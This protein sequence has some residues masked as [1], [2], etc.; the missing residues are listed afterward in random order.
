MSAAT[1][2]VALALLLGPP[3]EAHGPVHAQEVL[4]RCRELLTSMR[5]KQAVLLAEEGLAAGDA[6]P[7]EVK[8]L[9]LVLAEASAAIN[10]LDASRTA[11]EHVLL[12]DPSFTLSSLAS[13]KLREPFEA[14]Q[15]EVGQVRL[16]VVPTVLPIGPSRYRARITVEGDRFHWVHSG[17][18]Y[19]Q[20]GAE[21]VPV[22]LVPAEELVAELECPS[23][24][25]YYLVLRDAAGNALLELGSASALLFPELPESPAP[26]PVSAPAAAPPVAI[27][28]P[29][30][31]PPRP[32][33]RH[34][35]TYLVPAAVFAVAGA[36]LGWQ[37]SATEQALISANADRSQHSLAE[38]QQMDRL[39]LAEHGAMLTCVGV[40]LAI[41]VVGVAVW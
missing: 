39:R 35:A 24:C 5:Y 32:W 29:P 28:A 34:P 20:R 1:S 19:V 8:A 33:Y 9:Y 17:T 11:F 26:E 6:R 38:L 21:F 40:A 23:R 10:M 30:L 3:D 16:K 27:S 12:L 14:A 13:P 22:D 41:A 15:R 36:V 4:E 31:A 7:A 18:L 37:Y 2:L 25:G